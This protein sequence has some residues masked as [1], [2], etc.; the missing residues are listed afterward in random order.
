M[1]MSD[2]FLCCDS[3]FHEL[4]IKSSRA[5]KLWID[6]CAIYCKSEGNFGLLVEEESELLSIRMLETLG[7]LVSVENEV[8][9]V[10]HINGQENDDSGVYFCPGG[11]CH[12]H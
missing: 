7:Y 5:A 12:D 11:C 3:C 4:A 10:I 6:L 1:K 2:A 8:G 9:L